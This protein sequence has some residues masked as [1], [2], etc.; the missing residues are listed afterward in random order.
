MSPFSL[1][2]GLSHPEINFSPGD[3]TETADLGGLRRA[4]TKTKTKNARRFSRFDGPL[5]ITRVL[6]RAAR[7][8]TNDE[9]SANR[10]S[11]GKLP[12]PVAFRETVRIHPLARSLAPYLLPVRAILA[13]SVQ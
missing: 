11:P 9:R 5:T 4:A 3:S 2:E 10:D 13:A 1:N 7:S 12:R 8:L 6:A